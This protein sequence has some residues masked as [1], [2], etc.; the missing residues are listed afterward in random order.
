MWMKKYIIRKSIL[1]DQETTSLLQEASKQGRKSE[2]VIVRQ[3]I[4]DRFSNPLDAIKKEKIEIARK[5]NEL[6]EREAR[7]S[8]LMDNEVKNGRWGFNII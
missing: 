8:Q 6:V 3:L 2:S 5:L 4:K 1:L 7:I